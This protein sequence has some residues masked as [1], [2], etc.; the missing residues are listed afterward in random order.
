VSEFTTQLEVGISQALDMFGNSATY[1]RADTGASLSL[2]VMPVEPEYLLSS[3]GG[4]IRAAADRWDVLLRTADL[5]FGGT[6][7][8][9]KL[10]DSITVGAQVY[11][12]LVEDGQHYCWAWVDHDMIRRRLKTKRTAAAG[13]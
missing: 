6:Q 1:T 3:D 13:G 10:G 4:V 7:Y 2:N 11:T 12:V 9:P 8:E 5:T